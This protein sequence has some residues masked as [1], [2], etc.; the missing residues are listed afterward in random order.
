[1]TSCNLCKLVSGTFIGMLF[2]KYLMPAKKL[3]KM[4]FLQHTLC[5]M[6]TFVILLG[7]MSVDQLI[8]NILVH[9]VLKCGSHHIH[10]STAAL[11]SGSYILHHNTHVLC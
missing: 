10:G 9:S 8:S 4:E 7:L 6:M 3:L 11:H 1:M 5:Y 2:M